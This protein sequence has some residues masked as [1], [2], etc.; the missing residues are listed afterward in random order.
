MVSIE[1]RK[2]ALARALFDLENEALL[3]AIEELISLEQ[4]HKGEAW[5][6]TQEELQGIKDALKTVEGGKF[7]SEEEVKERYKKWLK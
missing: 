5:K 4:Q 3:T 7:Y 6:P 1:S 2:I